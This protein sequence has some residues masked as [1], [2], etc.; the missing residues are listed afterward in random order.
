M[1]SPGLGTLTSIILILY[2][3]KY[4]FKIN[5]CRLLKLLVEPLAGEALAFLILI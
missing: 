3:I 2:L 5:S 1:D 4:F